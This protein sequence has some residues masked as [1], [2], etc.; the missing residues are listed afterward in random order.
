MKFTSLAILIIAGSANAFLPANTNQISFRSISEPKLF[1]AKKP[2]K[3]VSKKSGKKK[4]GAK[5]KTAGVLAGAAPLV[6]TPL[7]GI[8]A[9][10]SFL[11]NTVS[12]REK[13]ERE[14]TVKKAAKEKTDPTSTEIDFGGLALAAG[15]F[16]AAALSLG[17][18][19]APVLSNAP[20]PTSGEMVKIVQAEKPPV[21]KFDPSALFADKIK[22]TENVK[23]EKD[24]LRQAKKN[25]SINEV[26]EKKAEKEL[27]VKTDVAMKEEQALASVEKK[28][29]AETVDAQ[30]AKVA[31]AEADK[32]AAE[33]KEAK[34]KDAAKAAES[35]LTEE[36]KTEKKAE[37]ESIQ[38]SK[39]APSPDKKKATAP[40]ATKANGL[41]VVKGGEK[42]GK[43]LPKEDVSGEALEFIKKYSTV[44]NQ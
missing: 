24:A 3:A 11:T 7:A 32:K 34:A 9:G 27:R 18:I 16:A 29:D 15:S 30:K 37:K 38:K 28:A 4:S 43:I 13:I 23:S 21:S 26:A 40:K 2:S 22:A 19:V 12:R 8:V 6:L 36:I 5:A 25:V 42:G 33:E 35:K 14:I 41:G 17:I 1:A 10:R 31:E 44:T 20:S 39:D